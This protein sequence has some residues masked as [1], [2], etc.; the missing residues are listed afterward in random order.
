MVGLHDTD[1]GNV[2]AW[3]GSIVTSG[4]LGA[5][6]YTLIRDRR[7]EERTQIQQ[8]IVQK[9][10]SQTL[11]TNGIR[12][13]ILTL[14]NTSPLSFY[15]AAVL[16]FEPYKK[17]YNFANVLPAG[18]RPIR[19]WWRV[20]QMR[21]V[22][23]NGKW[24]TGLFLGHHDKKTES[25]QNLPPGQITTAIITENNSSPAS[26]TVLMIQDATGRAWAVEPISAS[27][28]RADVLL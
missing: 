2:P 3:V 5:L 8:L 12:A 7:K 20:R 27:T 25:L 9:G 16:T 14:H 19:R 26:L 10:R 4:S 18:K 24:E 15:K 1:W 11:S 21:K 13:P 6:S 22:L 23:L 28:F 17:R